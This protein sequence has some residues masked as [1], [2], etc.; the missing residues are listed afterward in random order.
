MPA[1]A[2]VRHPSS[3]SPARS[4]EASFDLNECGEATFRYWVRGA[5]AELL[6]APTR[7][8]RRRSNLWETTCFEAFIRPA[9]GEG[10]VEFNFSPS[11]EWAAW[12]L[13]GYRAGFRPAPDCPPP[14]M[15]RTQRLGA[16]DLAVTLAFDWLPFAPARLGLSAILEDRTGGK[17]FWALRHPPG[18]PDFHHADCF[19]YEL[20]ERPH[21]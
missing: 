17:S 1:A 2:L 14:V 10:Y 13:D 5:T 21:P 20:T 3:P 7:T 9:G 8:P 16:F 12:R 11:G 4:V 18:A 6:I 15:R 19:A